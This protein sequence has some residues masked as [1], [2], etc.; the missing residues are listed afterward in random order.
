LIAGLLHHALILPIL[1]PLVTGSIL[2]FFNERRY[3]L[4][5]ALSL[6]SASLLVVV[7]VV[8]LFRA[9]G[10]DPVSD[11]Y[12]LGNWPAPFGIILVLDRLS[13]VMLLLASVLGLCSLVFSLA[14]WHKVGTNFHSLLHFLLVGINGA[15]LTGD[16][17]NL[18]VFFEV[19]LTASY[20]LVLHG[21]GT[22]R[23]RAGMHYVV[24]NL[25]ASS[26]FL[27][28]VSLIY[29]VTGT[30]NMADLAAKV[31]RI[32]ADKQ[33][34]FEVG[35]T[36]LGIAFLVKA[37]MWPLCFW[38][39]SAYSAA[40]APVGAVFAILTKVGIYIILRLSLLIFGTESGAFTEFGNAL[41]FYG[42]LVTIA[43]GMVG[44]LASQALGRL[45]AYCVLISSGT[46]LAAIG[47]GNPML[48]SVVVYYMISSTLALAAF[49]LLIELV[50]RSQDTAANVL[51]V[52]MEV[53]GDDEIEDEDEVGFY[54]PATLAILGACFGICAILII[55]MPPFSG[56]LAKFML[57][58]GVFDSGG[59]ESTRYTPDARD[60]IYVIMIVLG[61]FAA[62][63]AM[64]RAGVRTFWA[65]I[66]GKVPKVQMIEVIPV[67][68]LLSLCLVM[69]L[70]ADPVIRYMD[71]M[72]ARLHTPS[73]Y[74]RS[75][76]GNSSDLEGWEAL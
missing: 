50:E 56:F 47:T 7:A 3:I 23:V 76:L 62:L 44:V 32:S 59:V 31:S 68:A 9:K 18:F 51:A 11:V 34:L 64:T 6:G 29:G 37:G 46:A 54:I 30:L 66:E 24:I 4:K 71:T 63:I 27:I 43:F 33:I 22:V 15:F 74:I 17:F 58:A 60:W 48:T 52:T 53:Y 21:S 45:A 70:T 57:I 49:F 2:L 19:M 36:I 20:A 67:V 65:S 1:L 26:C 40:A 5:S 12:H 14:H 41:I 16:V 35:A 13:A 38:L 8:L 25:V 39:P 69:T 42:G 72:A 75:V 10:V 55:G 28:G 73:D 61:G